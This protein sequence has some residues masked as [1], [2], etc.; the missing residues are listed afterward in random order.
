M[1][2]KKHPRLA[3]VVAR[4]R[5]AVQL[6]PG[7]TLKRLGYKKG[8]IRLEAALPTEF[9]EPSPGSKP[10]SSTPRALPILAS[11]MLSA[12]RMVRASA[13][14]AKRLRRQPAPAV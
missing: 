1:R 2:E 9:A 7:V 14:I 10:F 12:Y 6:P 11:M 5:G 8:R 3:Q 13:K 4:G